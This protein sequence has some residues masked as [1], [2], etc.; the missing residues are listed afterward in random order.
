MTHK[1]TKTFLTV[2][3][4]VVDKIEEMDGPITLPEGKEEKIRRAVQVEKPK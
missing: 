3:K 2:L 1:A 4:S